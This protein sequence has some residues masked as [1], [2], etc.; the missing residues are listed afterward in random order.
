MKNIFENTNCIPLKVDKSPKQKKIEPSFYYDLD[1][2]EDNIG[3]IVQS[4]Y[5]YLDFDDGS[6]GDVLLEIVNDL[7]LKT[8]MIE[9]T[10]GRHFIFKTDK[11]KY[12]D[13][14]HQNIWGGL[15]CDS[16]GN[17]T[18]EYR[19][20]Y[21]VIKQKGKVRKQTNLNCESLSEVDVLPK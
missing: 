15:L 7:K 6:Y 19:I 9:T 5:C 17:G 11:E 1:S 3:W 4:G 10:R 16:K 2:T 12:K 20:K 18:N 14:T 13:W 8:I 21:E